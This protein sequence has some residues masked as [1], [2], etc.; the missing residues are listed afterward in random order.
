MHF[1][2]ASLFLMIAS[3]LATFNILKP[4]DEH[5]N[6]YTPKEEYLSSI[7]VYA[8]FFDK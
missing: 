1:A 7:M 6:E 2:D 4:I 5:G 8:F 3:V